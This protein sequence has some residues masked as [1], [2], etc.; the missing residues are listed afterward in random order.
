MNYKKVLRKLSKKEN[1]PVKELEQEMEKAIRA[2]GLTCSV[3][4]FIS[5]TANTVSKRLYIVD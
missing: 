4:E 2:A 3:K 5:K 1:V